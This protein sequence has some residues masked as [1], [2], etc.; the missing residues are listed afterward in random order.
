MALTCDRVRELASGFV[1]GALDTNEMIAVADHLDSCTRPHREIGDLGGVLPYLAASLEPIEPPSWLRESV[2]NAA[3][4]DLVA[5]SHSAEPIALP[6]VAAVAPA[7]QDAGFA[8]ASNLVSLSRA[9]VSRRRRA[10][11]FA[12]RVAAA[13][14][15]VALAGYAF[16]LQGDLDKAKKAQEAD[17][18]LSY[19]WAQP[20]T[21][22]TV[23]TATDSSGAS[24][25]A[26]LR[27]T[28][29]IIVRVHGLATTK[30]DEVYAVWYSSGGS[31]V[32][33]AGTFTVDDSGSGGLEVNKVPTSADLWV[34]VCRE[35]NA[36]VTKPT[37]PEIVGGTISF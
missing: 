13:V 22:K 19:M 29:H 6:V 3:R 11:T 14:A 4:A 21:Y 15:V 30:G 36:G 34:F 27:P 16:V 28:G 26:A 1:L 24:G 7:A 10:M 9:R 23:L 17:A 32:T 5:R 25:M 8:P 33:K 35:P 12:T 31:P 2:I 18:S 20:D 37:G